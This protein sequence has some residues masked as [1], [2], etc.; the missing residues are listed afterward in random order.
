[1]QGTLG[2]GKFHLEIVKHYPVMENGTNVEKFYLMV[3]LT[4]KKQLLEF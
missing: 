4:L 2:C 1:L 3:F